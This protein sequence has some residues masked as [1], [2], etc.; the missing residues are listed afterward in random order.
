MNTS[1]YRI[2]TLISLRVRYKVLHIRWFDTD[3]RKRFCGR[4]QQQMSE[5]RE[6][7][8]ILGPKGKEQSDNWRNLQRST[9]LQFVVLS[10]II[11]AMKWRQTNLVGSYE[12]TPRKTNTHKRFLGTHGSKILFWLGRHVWKDNINRDLHSTWEGTVEGKHLVDTV[13]NWWLAVRMEKVSTNRGTELCPLN[14]VLWKISSA[15]SMAKKFLSG[16]RYEEPFQMWLVTFNLQF[17][18]LKRPSGLR[19]G[20]TADHVLGLWVRIPRGAWMSVSFKCCVVR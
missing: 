7:R 9:E 1:S 16:T 4:K 14:S 19:R 5:N 18:D 12:S 6:L 8:R 17:A 11:K 20:F 2:I 15:F 3:T 10:D 13:M